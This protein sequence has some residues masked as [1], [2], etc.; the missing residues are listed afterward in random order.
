ML[1]APES[2]FFAPVFFSFFPMQVPLDGKMNQKGETGRDNL[3]VVFQLL[4]AATHKMASR[5]CACKKIIRGDQLG[6]IERKLLAD[7]LQS[8]SGV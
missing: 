1:L 2:I 3:S 5:S 6:L 7:L 8:R 4:L